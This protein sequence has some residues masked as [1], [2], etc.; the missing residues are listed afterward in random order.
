MTLYQFKVTYTDGGVE[1]LDL[2]KEELDK[3]FINVIYPYRTMID[4]NAMLRIA[5]ER[6]KEFNSG[7]KGD[8]K[9]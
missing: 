5:K 4:V 6:H 1:I 9:E 8:I 3:I 7:I 2:T